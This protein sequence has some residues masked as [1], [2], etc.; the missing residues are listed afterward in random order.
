MHFV[1]LLLI[2]VIPMVLLNFLS[3]VIPLLF[4]LKILLPPFQAGCLASLY[5]DQF[6]RAEPAPG[7]TVGPESFAVTKEEFEPEPAGA[8]VPAQQAEAAVEPAEE[9]E[10]NKPVEDE[11]PMK[12]VDD[13]QFSS[14]EDEEGKQEN[15]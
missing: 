11:K 6:G 14:K 8:E 13:T 12:G 5:I 1:F 4:V 10:E 3:A 15:S 7:A 2:T 9:V